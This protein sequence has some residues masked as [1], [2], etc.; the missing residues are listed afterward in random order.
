MESR[1][2]EFLNWAGPVVQIAS[3]VLS[4]VF[5][6]TENVLVQEFIP[7]INVTQIGLETMS[8]V[9]KQFSATPKKPLRDHRDAN[10]KRVVEMIRLGSL[11][12]VLMTFVAVPLMR[13]FGVLTEA[14]VYFSYGMTSSLSFVLWLFLTVV[15]EKWIC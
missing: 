1:A 5:Y 11:F 9:S 12:L 10:R 6:F 7:A 3:I 2:R 14:E 8:I 13:T 15:P 4:F